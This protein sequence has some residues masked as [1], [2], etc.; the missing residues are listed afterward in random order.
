VTLRGKE[1]GER[2]GV[3]DIYL[4]KINPTVILLDLR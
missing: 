2:G 1:W 3:D 4:E